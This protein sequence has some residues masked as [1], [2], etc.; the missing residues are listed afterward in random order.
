MQSIG[1]IVYFLLPVILGG[2]TNMVFVKLPVAAA[3]KK[4]IDRG[5][6]LKDGERF[7]G[8]NKTW[9]GFLGM[10]LFTSLWMGV[11]AQVSRSFP[12]VSGFSLI[13]YEAFRFPLNEWFY[14]AVWGFGYVLFELPNSYIKRRL[15][16]PPGK[17]AAGF[18]GILFTFIDQ[19][20]SVIGCMV[21][22]LFFYVPGAA[23]AFMIFLVGTG[24]HYFV[25]ILLFGVGLK[26]QAH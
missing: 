3:L 4:P 17:N 16:I 1:Q 8:D 23:E 6:R 5:L 15:N 13:D 25:N 11:V 20:D 7:L 12:W 9:K 21:F 22:M 24:V 10:I 18:R 26:T 2:I 19:A 14:G